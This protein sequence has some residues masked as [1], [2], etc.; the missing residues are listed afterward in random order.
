M[1]GVPWLTEICSPLRHWPSWAAAKRYAFAR[2]ELKKRF[3]FSGLF[4]QG[5]DVTRKG[6]V[7][8]ERLG[9]SCGYS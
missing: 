4:L 7:G 5:V 9:T 8:T 1:L 6:L 2:S 3:P